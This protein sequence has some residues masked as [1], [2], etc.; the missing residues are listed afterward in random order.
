[1]RPFRMKLKWKKTG[2]E[3]EDFEKPCI[4]FE[5]PYKC[6]CYCC[7]RPEMTGTNHKDGID[8]GK[9][10]DDWR[11]CDPSFQIFDQ[12][13]KKKYKIAG[14][15]CQCGLMCKTCSPFYETKFFIY[16][17]DAN[18]DPS[19]AVGS[20]VRKSRECFKAMFTDADEFNVYFPK[21]ATAYDKLMLI[22]T[23]L[24]IDYTYFEE[25]NSPE[26]DIDGG[27]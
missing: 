26:G 16:D 27:F 13:N 25:D 5:K 6:A 15:C 23:T 11:C 19:N 1:M 18:E 22:G 2:K 7:C 8:F 14:S 17:A 3:A 24:M 20:I 4:T 9:V 10:V 12:E 21:N